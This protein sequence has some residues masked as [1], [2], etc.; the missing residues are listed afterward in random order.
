MNENALVYNG[1]DRF[2]C[3]KKLVEDLKI[4]AY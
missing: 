2:L 1:L 4:V 3:R